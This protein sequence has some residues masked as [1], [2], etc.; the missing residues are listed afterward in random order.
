MS[1]PRRDPYTVST[2][3]RYDKEFYTEQEAAE[4]LGISLQR[5]H[6]LLDQKVFH[7]GLQRPVQ[8]NFLQTDLVLLAI[9][10]REEPANLV[11]MPRR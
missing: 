3:L 7:D 11:R 2:P 5:L 8:L 4:S 6:S 10:H 9:W 1:I